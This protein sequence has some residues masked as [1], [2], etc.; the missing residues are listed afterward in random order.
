MLGGGGTKLALVLLLSVQIFTEAILGLEFLINYET[1][2]GFPGRRITPR[3]NEEVFYFEFTGAKRTSSNRFCDLG[4]M[5]L[6]PQTQHPSTAVNKCHCYTKNFATGCVDESVQGRKRET[7]TYML[8]NDEE[9]EYL[10][11][12][13]NE[14]SA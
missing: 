2:I 1:E 5:S 10:L 14:V 13:D 7:G 11:N 8:D 9:C 6:H 4:L 12:N 3:V